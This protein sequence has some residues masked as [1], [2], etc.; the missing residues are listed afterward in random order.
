MPLIPLA[1]PAALSR[2]KYYWGR[3]PSL[4]SCSQ[5][6]S[7]A[8]VTRP[9]KEEKGGTKMPPPPCPARKKGKETDRASLKN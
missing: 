3:P 8:T 1:L 2:W 6:E 4:P 5:A 7:S 9:G